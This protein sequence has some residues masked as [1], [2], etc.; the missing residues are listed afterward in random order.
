[1][2]YNFD[3]IIDRKN[4]SCSKYDA[5][6]IYFGYEDLQPLWVADMDFKTPDVVNNVIL[7]RAKKGLYGYP[8]ATQRTFDA[9]KNWMKKRHNWNIDT[10]WITFVNGV[11]PAYSAAIEAFSEVGDEVIVQTPVYFPLFKHIKSNNRVLVT[12]PLKENNGYYTM[13]LEDLKK[14]ITPKTKIFVLCSP[15]NPVGRVWSKEELKELA[16]ICLDNNILIIS[17]EIHSDIVF[18]KFTPIATI[19]DE[20]AMNTLTLN[21]PGKTFNTAGLKCGY[22]ISKNSEIMNTFKTIIEKREVKSINVFGF[23]ALEAAYELGDSW[24]DELLVYLKKN[25]NFTKDFLEKNNSK[26]EFLEPEATYLLWLS[27]KKITNDYNKVKQKLLEESKVAL[28]EG[29]TFG[30][31]GKGYFRLNCALPQSELEK[32]LSKIVTFF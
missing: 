22:A 9:V 24:L 17:D 1:M 18:K 3:E 10:S 27:F 2:I 26:I 6:D 23:T 14:K 13:D 25:I 32:G 30:R 29:S 4:T 19:S 8:I 15:H 20:I 16:Q 31:E 21:S 12:N 28:N 7:E 11:V 5:L